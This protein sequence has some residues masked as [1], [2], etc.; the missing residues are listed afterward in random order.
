MFQGSAPPHLLDLPV[1]VLAVAIGFIALESREASWRPFSTVQLVCRKFRAAQICLLE[2]RLTSKMRSGGTWEPSPSKSSQLS[3]RILLALPYMTSTVLSSLRCL[4]FCLFAHC[5][6]DAA[7]E[8][9]TVMGDH[10]LEILDMSG[11]DKVTETSLARLP[12]IPSL[13]T[14]SLDCCSQVT[15]LTVKRLVSAFP[16]ISRLSMARCEKLTDASVERLSTLSKLDFLTLRDCDKLTFLGFRDFAGSMKVL[17]HLVVSGCRQLTDSALKIFA[18]MEQLVSLDISRCPKVTDIGI[19]NLAE[20]SRLTN[21]NLA[22]CSQLTDHG[23]K[24]LGLLSTLREL[25]LSECRALTDTAVKG[26]AALPHLEF[27]FLDRCDRITDGSVRYLMHRQSPT[28]MNQIHTLDLS[29]N[30]KISDVALADLA[31]F[32]C[33]VGLRL[34]V[35]NGITD[36]GL[37]ELIKSPSLRDVCV[38]RCRRISDAGVA[39]LRERSLLP[40]WHL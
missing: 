22:A 11:A 35:C 5:L 19:A 39:C 12:S 13:H 23:V 30:H 37:Q 24:K 6:T 9:L 25:R 21:L 4:S 28:I 15:T 14:L 20:R 7:V 36:V 2:C 1:E 32:P 34:V 40:Q 29:F 27:L 31:Q 16:N 38:E 3:H 8:C 10:Q 33:L 17:R 18:E 26:L